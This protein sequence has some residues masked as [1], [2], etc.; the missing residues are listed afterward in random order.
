[1]R[2]Y[3][4]TNDIKSGLQNG[5]L[6][7]AYGASTDVLWASLRR[8]LKAVH[9][10]KNPGVPAEVACEAVRI[11]TDLRSKMA[12]SPPRNA[13]MM[14][15]FLLYT[16]YFVCFLPFDAQG[17]LLATRY[18]GHGGQTAHRDKNFDEK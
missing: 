5:T 11:V 13:F 6:D 16:F 4:S 3:A 8:T 9:P 17:H 15:Y 14:I 12:G 2:A 18:R 10:D 1:M 7:V